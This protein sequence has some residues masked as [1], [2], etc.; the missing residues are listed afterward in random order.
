[1][2][3]VEVVSAA[4]QL[5]RAAQTRADREVRPLSVMALRVEGRLTHARLALSPSQEQ[6]R[7][8]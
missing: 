5:L 8:S 2:C 1:M 4:A 7:S 3:M 6:A